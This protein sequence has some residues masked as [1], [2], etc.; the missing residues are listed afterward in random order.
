MT[1]KHVL[2]HF[3]L[4]SAP[5]SRAVPD[6][7]LL[8]H[9]SFE[10]AS[11][12]ILFALETKTPALLTADP[13]VGKSTLLAA[14]SDALD[15]ARTRLVYTALCSCGPY[16]LIGQ[17]AV[18]YAIRPRRSS[19]QT[20]QALLAEL[21]RSERTEILVLDEAH[22]LP[23]E[24]LD[25]LRL[26]SNTDF[27]RTPPFF[28]L[29][30]GQP[31]LRERL[32]EPDLASLWQRIAV[33]TS[34]TPLSERETADYVDRRMRA[35]GAQAQPFRKGAIDPLFEHSRGVPRVINN[36]AVGALLAAATAGRKHV[37]AADIET[38]RFAMEA[39]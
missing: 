36:L 18:Q 10:E 5:F 14:I 19:A 32:Q 9:K 17:L 21:A 37:E 23:R 35:A 15:A 34:L 38:S 30:C 20:A 1:M 39:A 25:E 22:R 8:R 2:Q 26:I 3:G 6:A 4:H 11:A 29:L 7:A 16:G 27:D 12:R 24:S 13:G 33:R 31:P 28:L